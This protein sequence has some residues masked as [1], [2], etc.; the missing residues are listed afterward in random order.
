VEPADNAGP[1]CERCAL[2]HVRCA[3]NAPCDGRPREIASRP[4]RFVTC[5]TT[6]SVAGFRTSITSPFFSTVNYNPP[7]DKEALRRQLDDMEEAIGTVADGKT[8][9]LN[10]EIDK[11]RNRI[12]PKPKRGSASQAHE[13]GGRTRKP[14]GHRPSAAIRQDFRKQPRQNFRNPPKNGPAERAK[15]KSQINPPGR[16]PSRRRSA[17]PAFPIPCARNPVR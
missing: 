5:P 8:D 6:S 12:W 10:A 14:Q 9:A 13:L 15:L 16:P 2:S 7:M 11:P 1:V 4:A 3:F 17:R